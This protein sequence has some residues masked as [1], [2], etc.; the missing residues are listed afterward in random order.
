MCTRCTSCSGCC[1][2][3]Q[4][5]AFRCVSLRNCRNCHVNQ[6]SGQSTFW[7]ECF[8]LTS[9]CHLTVGCSCCLK[10]KQIKI[11]YTQEEDDDTDLLRLNT[12]QFLDS[13]W[14][15]YEY[16]PTSYYWIMYRRPT[17][18]YVLLFLLSFIERHMPDKGQEFVTLVCLLL[19]WGRW[20]RTPC[21]PPCWW[22]WSWSRCEVERMLVACLGRRANTAPWES[23]SCTVWN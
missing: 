9:I 19:R 13:C 12:T 10:S 21:S 11:V 3:L 22:G 4:I 1:W 14:A 8:L 5:G 2:W 15:S 7:I 23:C 17:Q 18:L 16:K 6:F 20:W